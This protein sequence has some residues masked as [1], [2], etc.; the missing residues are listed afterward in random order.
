[1]ASLYLRLENE[2]GS[3]R[4]YKK[5]K[6]KAYW[7]KEALKHAK[8]VDKLEAEGNTEKILDARLRFTCSIFGDRDLTPDAILNGMECDQIWDKLDEV[9]HTVMGRGKKVVETDPGKR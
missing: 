3:F 4:E 5:E 1:M 2:D 6:I 8:E 9:F 7:V